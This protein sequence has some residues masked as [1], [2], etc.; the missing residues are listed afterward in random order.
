[1]DN[2]G[3]MDKFLETH[4]LPRLYQEEIECLN[5]PI[6]NK[7]IDVV[8]KNPLIKKSTGPDGFIAEFY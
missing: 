1:M 5:R 2:K 7:E 4:N 8:I 6:T 3:E